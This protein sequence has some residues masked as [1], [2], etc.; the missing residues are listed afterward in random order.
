MLVN[1]FYEVSVTLIPKTE[2][3]TKKEKKRKKRKTVD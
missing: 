3:Y 2:D 1:S